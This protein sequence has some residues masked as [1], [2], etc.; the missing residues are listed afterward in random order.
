MEALA[1]HWREFSAYCAMVISMMSFSHG[2]V[3]T[4]VDGAPVPCLVGEGRPKPPSLLDVVR[5]SLA[6]SS[7]MGHCADE[8]PL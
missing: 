3:M 7:I 6:E 4:G 5:N 8:A 2:V 1:R